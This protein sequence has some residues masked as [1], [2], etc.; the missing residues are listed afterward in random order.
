VAAERPEVAWAYVGT[1]AERRRATGVLAVLWAVAVARWAL[2]VGFLAALASLGGLMAYGLWIAKDTGGAMPEWWDRAVLVAAVVGLVV[3]AV[4][5]FFVIPFRRWRFQ[6]RVLDQSG[7]EP[8][9]GPAAAVVEDLVE[10]LSIAAGCQVPRVLRCPSPALNAFAVGTEV[11][12]AA[13]VLT[14]GVLALPRRQLEAVLAYELGLIAGGEV[15]LTTWIVVLTNGSDLSWM[16][17][18]LRAWALR[19]S[20]LQRD[21]VAVSFTRDPGALADAFAA[22]AADPGVPEGFAVEDAPVW[23]EFPDGTGSA[24]T[25]RFYDD[26]RD[27]MALDRRIAALDA[28]AVEG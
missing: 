21:R 15:R 1:D 5:S 12:D 7:A 19:T 27:A 24:F 25:R 8:I 17:L 22:V 18:G 9:V 20:A 11:D 14:D 10:G 23:L 4:V 28:A 3:G 13:L 26:I 2:I 6:Q 16:R